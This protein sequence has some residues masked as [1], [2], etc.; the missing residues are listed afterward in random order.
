M[1]KLMQHAAEHKYAVGYFESW[2]MESML[3]VM[4]AAERTQSP[5][6]IGFGGMFVGNP[7]RRVEEDIRHYGALGCAVAENSKVPTALLLNE[8]VDESLLVKGLIAGF[9]AIMYANPET[10]FE[11]TIAINQYLVKTAH[12]CGAAVEAE[13][14]ELPTADIATG[15]MS[16]GELTDPERAA[17]FVKA[18]GVDALAV[19]VGNVHLLEGRKSTLD[20]DLIK[21]L[22]KAVNVPLVLHGGT[23]VSPDEMREAI[24]LGMRKINVGT[25]LKRVFLNTVTQYLV[26]NDTA[27]MDPH[28]VIGKGGEDDML[29]IARAAMADRIAE[30]M[31]N[32]GCCGKA[33]LF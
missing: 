13:I 4:D 5:V 33:E 12:F 17:Y 10:S 18:T 11:D 3:A 15:T 27:Q 14:G 26:E 19:A 24:A 30:M 7:A 23:G 31:V 32:F 2:D 25:M 20:F 6:I 9:N 1:T 8:A 29:C 28:E 21:R 22:K 16:E